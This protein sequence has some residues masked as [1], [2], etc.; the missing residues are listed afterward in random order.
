MATYQNI[1]SYTVA[2]SST[3]SFE[4]TSIPNTYT[5]LCL[6]VSARLDRAGQSRTPIRITLNNNTNDY[7]WIRFAAY[8]GNNQAAETANAQNF[9]YFLDAAAST[10]ATSVFSSGLFY[11]GGYASSVFKTYSSDNVTPNADVTTPFVMEWNGGRWQNNTAIS[12]IKISGD[13]YNFLAN[14]TAYLYGISNA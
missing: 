6:W 9:A 5:D 11:I 14:T 2:G 3:S 4:F 1:G 13:G 12:S 10:T 7:D 8:D